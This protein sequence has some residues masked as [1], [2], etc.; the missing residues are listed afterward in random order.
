VRPFGLVARVSNRGISLGLERVLVDFGADTS[1]AKSVG[2]VREH[3]RIQVNESMVRE[4]TLKH[5]E[6]MQMEIEVEARMPLSGVKQMLSEMDGMF[7]PLVRT[8]GIGDARKGR[9]CEYGEAKMC[10]AGQVGAVRRRYR[11]TMGKAEAAGRM[12]K[13][14][15]VESGG[16]LETE[17][18]CLG[19]G[20]KWIEVQVKKQFGAKAKYLVDFYHLSD[21]LAA[22]GEALK[23][24][25]GENWLREQQ[26]RLKRNE[27]E[28]VL[29]ELRGRQE[30][31]EV[32]EINAP[33]R[34]CYKYLEERSGQVDYQGAIEQGFPIGSGEI[35]SGNKSVLQARLKIAGA[36]WKVENAEKMIGV[37]TNRAN[38]DWESYWKQQRVATA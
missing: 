1:F 35:E 16:G 6:A 10:L 5:G 19:D 22:A 32:G 34:R 28:K 30:G 29:K 36:W 25:E 13:A 24:R 7:V 20:A 38:G 33:I 37:R 8:E 4:A 2:K 3:Y 23:G 18:H 21:Y 9:I 26:A 12:W 15:V 14:C 31:L 17:L 27:A 11:A